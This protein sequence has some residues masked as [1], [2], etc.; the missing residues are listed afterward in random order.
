M[1]SETAAYAA[2]TGGCSNGTDNIT[3]LQ[4][5][6]PGF[7]PGPN[8]R[9]SYCIELDVNL[10]GAAT[11]NCFRAQAFGNAGTRVNNEI[12]AIDCTNAKNY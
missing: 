11:A 7:Q 12:Y 3:L 8:P 1:F 5:V 2:D 9:F 4:G 6:F 10:A